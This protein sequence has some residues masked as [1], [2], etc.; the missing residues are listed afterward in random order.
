MSVAKNADICRE[1]KI[2][3][4]AF[5]M[6]GRCAACESTR[7]KGHDSCPFYKTRETRQIEHM[8][9]VHHLEAIG[10][11]DLIEKYGTEGEQTRVWSEI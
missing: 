9:N 5:G 3:C 2:D 8:N 11:F 10:R 4:F 6:Y 7:F 1:G